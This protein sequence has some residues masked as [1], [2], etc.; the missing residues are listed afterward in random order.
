MRRCILI[1]TAC[2]PMFLAQTGLSESAEANGFDSLL[3]QG[4][5]LH[6][7]NQYAQALPLL[8]RAWNIQP[9]D[10]FANLL[11]G[12]DLLRTGKRAEALSF[13]REAARVR[14]QE[15]FP[16]EYLGEAE[17]GLRHYAAAA[18]SYAC[19]TRVAPQSAQA[20]IAFVDFSLARFGEMAGLLRSSRPGLAAEYRLQAL[21]HSVADP[22][23][24]Q[25]SGASG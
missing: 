1:L 8:R 9:H 10:Y 12:I 11:I 19:A 5:D 2:L 21:A 22:E 4:F 20:A 24:L 17:A 14:P 7:R 23:R 16:C 3:H 13:L 18:E 15:E 6:Q 25:G